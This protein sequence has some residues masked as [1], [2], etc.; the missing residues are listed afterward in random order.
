MRHARVGSILITV[1][2]ILLLFK[3]FGAAVGSIGG[4]LLAILVVLLLLRL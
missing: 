1:L 4:L 2:V 3:L